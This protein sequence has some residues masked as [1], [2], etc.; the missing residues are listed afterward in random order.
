[1]GCSARF[2]YCLFPL[3]DLSVHPRPII[4]S[5][6]QPSPARFAQD[7]R[8]P[9]VMGTVHGQFVLPRQLASAMS[10]SPTSRTANA[11][12]VEE[13]P[14]N[15]RRT[16]GRAN[17]CFSAARRVTAHTRVRAKGPAVWAFVVPSSPSLLGR[18]SAPLDMH[19]VTGQSGTPTSQAHEIWHRP[20]LIS[21]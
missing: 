4:L 21:P 1:L 20:L 9:S 2:A 3:Q 8:S 18:F 13:K 6:S 11:S 14:E 5:S 10:Q 17:W 19:V 15:Q 16:K 12:R 7:R